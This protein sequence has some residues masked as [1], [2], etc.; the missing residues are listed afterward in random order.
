MPLH[1]PVIFAAFDIEL[2]ADVFYDYVLVKR[3]FE[4]WKQTWL[5]DKDSRTPR[6]PL[7]KFR[8]FVSS[9]SFISRMKQVPCPRG[10]RCFYHG[11]AS[12]G[13]LQAVSR[14]PT[15]AVRIP[16]PPI[17]AI[18]FDALPFCCFSHVTGTSGAS[19]AL[20]PAAGDARTSEPRQHLLH[21]QHRAMPRPRQRFSNGCPPTRFRRA[22]A[23]PFE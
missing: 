20:V 13:H 15:R 6:S 14:S 5:D 10:S 7:S 2:H 23:A 18:P 4:D 12:H 21:Q 8:T 11:A 19:F 17:D 3:A 9:F 1:A 16:V 22:P